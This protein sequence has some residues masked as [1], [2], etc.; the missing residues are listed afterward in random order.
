[1]MKSKWASQ[2][3]FVLTLFSCFSCSTTRKAAEHIK[4]NG[5]Q[6]AFAEEKNFIRQNLQELGAPAEMRLE[7]QSI[8]SLNGQTVYLGGSFLVQ[9]DLRTALF[10]STDGGRSWKEIEAFIGASSITDIDLVDGQN[11]SAFATYGIEGAYFNG[12]LRSQDGGLTWERFEA[13]RDEET[14][15]RIRSHISCCSERLFKGHFHSAKVGFALLGDERFILLK[16][17]DGGQT[18]EISRLLGD[19]SP[20]QAALSE[21]KRPSGPFEYRFVSSK[22]LNNAGVPV[23]TEIH[24]RMSGK[25]EWEKISELPALWK[26]DTVTLSA[27]PL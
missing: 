2:G 5:S 15:K 25:K 7:L 23:A 12:G 1:M 21:L 9:G 17:N 24:R 27:I 3:L 18:Y 16:T 4:L 14:Q 6:K 13:T 8:A 11:V 26:L 10:K 22:V 20:P 19:S